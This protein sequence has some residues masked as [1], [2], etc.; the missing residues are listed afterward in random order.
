MRM[1]SSFAALDV[2]VV[3]ADEAVGDHLDAQARELLNQRRVHAR[4]QDAD[5]R[6]PGGQVR[7]FEGGV[8][9]GISQLYAQLFAILLKIGGLVKLAVGIGK[10]LHLS[11]PLAESSLVYHSKC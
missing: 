7:V 2:H 3:H 11:S 8:F 6:I 1:P 10:Y 5:V 9:L 4:E